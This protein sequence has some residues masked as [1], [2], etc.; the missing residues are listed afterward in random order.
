[1]NPTKQRPYRYSAFD[2]TGTKIFGSI[3]AISNQDAKDK[4]ISNSMI[5]IRT[6]RQFLPNSIFSRKAKT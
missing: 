1:M 3:N 5:A 6:Y 2:I 4:L